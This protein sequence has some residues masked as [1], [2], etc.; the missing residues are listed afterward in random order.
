MRALVFTRPSVVEL[1]DVAEPA[2]AD[3]EVVVEVAVAGICGS[4]LHGIRHTEFRK[5]PLVMGHEFSGTTPDG[6]RVTVNP[7]ISCGTCDLCLLGQEHLCRNRAIL[8]INRAG[9][10]AER[11]VVPE[12]NVHEIPDSMSFET[13]A[14]VE[15]LANAVHALRLAAPAPGAR[16]A[17]IGAGTIGVV[18]LLVAL[19]YSDDVTVS[20]LD[21]DRLALAKSLGAANT[22]QQLDGEFDV[23]VDA[24]GAA[25]THK[26]SIDALRPGGVAVWI[27]L[28]SSDAAFDGQEIVRAEKR[29]LGSYCYRPG[30]F[31]A[32]LELASS[33]PLDWT[34]SFGLED[35]ARIFT[36]LMNGRHDVVKALIVPDGQ[37]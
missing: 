12:S 22:A 11:V 17:I 26:A 13:A 3:G 30:D 31:V 7:L 6:R 21:A 32:A 28:L 23:I 35:S 8:G 5:P 24:V 27:G 4:E 9:A 18:S 16:I 33:V 1:E 20:D 36:E 29:V 19:Q 25:S 15:P 2:V 34:T 10:F 14:M 37:V